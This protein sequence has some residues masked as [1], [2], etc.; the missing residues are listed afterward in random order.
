MGFGSNMHASYSAQTSGGSQMTDVF[1]GYSP[2]KAPQEVVHLT[3][4]E[5][6]ESIHV[7]PGW[8]LLPFMD[9]PLVWYHRQGGDNKDLVLCG[10][11]FSDGSQKG[12]DVCPACRA[13]DFYKETY[14]DNKKAYP[15]KGA[16][17]VMGIPFL[18]TRRQ[19]NK[20]LTTS[21][22]EI[23]PVYWLSLSISPYIQRE[24][25]LFLDIRDKMAP[26][27]PF[28]T[29]PYLVGAK[30]E[31]AMVNG[32][33]KSYGFSYYLHPYSN[34]AP[35]DVAIEVKHPV[36]D[37]FGNYTPEYVNMMQKLFL[38][39]FK[40]YVDPQTGQAEEYGGN[41]EAARQMQQA[42]RLAWPKPVS[43]EAVAVQ[44]VANYGAPL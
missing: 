27:F 21:G 24:A 17:L 31:G 8:F 16:A 18:A 20:H 15:I 6:P 2:K 33:W 13:F 29:T 4:M 9:T 44:P 12:S 39:R 38:A 32:E 35:S 14:G 22:K 43:Q 28:Q 7:E 23:L 1:F 41:L 36:L 30:P 42:C 3:G 10:K 25:N 5:R 11:T 40:A 34:A 37:F 19:R 26:Q